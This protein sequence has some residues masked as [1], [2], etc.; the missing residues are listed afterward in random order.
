[1]YDR[2]F[3][4]LKDEHDLTLLQSELQEII[5]ICNDYER[6]LMESEIK[7]LWKIIKNYGSA[8]PTNVALSLY[9]DIIKLYKN[10]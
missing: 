5:H 7:A 3:N 6:K 2:L 8:I 9:N 1:M 10:E 4:H